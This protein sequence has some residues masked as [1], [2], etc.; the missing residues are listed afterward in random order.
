MNRELVAA[1]CLASAQPNKRIK[2]LRKTPPPMPIIP[3]T[4][5]IVMPAI[6]KYLEGVTLD[7]LALPP[8]PMSLTFEDIKGP[9]DPRELKK[10]FQFMIIF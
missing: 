7:S 2:G 1:A 5:P 3:E 9:T 6:T 8:Q 10:M 4:K